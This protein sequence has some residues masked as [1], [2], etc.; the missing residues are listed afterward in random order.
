MCIENSQSHSSL[1]FTTPA[2][3][4]PPDDTSGLSGTVDVLFKKKASK[5]HPKSRF[6]AVNGQLGVLLAHGVGC[7]EE[8]A[9]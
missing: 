1:F 9:M 3:Y 6:N 5:V 4:Y 7:H 8:T 2:S